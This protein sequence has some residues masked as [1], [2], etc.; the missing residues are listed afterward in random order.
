MIIAVTHVLLPFMI[1]PM[2]RRPTNHSKGI[3]PGRPNLGAG[4]F[5]T[6]L[7]VT[8]PLSLPAVF[9]GTP[10]FILALGFY[11]TPALV[12]TLRP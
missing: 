5:T 2:L 9:A 6:S 10:I 12:A 4:V 8:L 1:L 3:A 11:V 7:K